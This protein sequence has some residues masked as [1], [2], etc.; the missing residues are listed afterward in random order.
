VKT[1]LKMTLAAALPL[2]SVMWLTP[3]ALA[4]DMP[5]SQEPR[6]SWSDA[7]SYRDPSTGRYIDSYRDPSTGFYTEWERR[8]RDN[9]SWDYGRKHRRYRKAMP[10]LS[11]PEWEARRRAPRHYGEQPQPFALEGT[12][13]QDRP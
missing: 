10:W 2:V 8:H 7:S 11:Y 12:P 6:R 1:P 9:S 4:H 3:P 13:G 5:R